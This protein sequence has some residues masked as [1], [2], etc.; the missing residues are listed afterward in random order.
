MPI[1]ATTSAIPIILAYD[2][3][4]KATTFVLNGRP[5]HKVWDF[6][7]LHTQDKILQF[8]FKV[9]DGVGAVDQRT[10]HECPCDV[11]AVVLL[12]YPLPLLPIAAQHRPSFPHPLQLLPL[13]LL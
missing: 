1:F 6:K 13:P 4:M 11:A 10:L 5:L 9:F 3:P 12:L 8:K 2:E 7:K